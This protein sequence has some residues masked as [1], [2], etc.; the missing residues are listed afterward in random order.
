MLA[1]IAN[2]IACMLLM[3]YT[4]PVSTL[5]GHKGM[6][7]HRLSLA[8]VLVALMLSAVNPWT[9]W[10]PPVSWPTAGLNIL[11]A[12]MVPIWWREAWNFL[13]SQYG[14]GPKRRATDFGVLYGG[15]HE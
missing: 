9:G 14:P 7:S 13:L 6:W 8:V 15:G 12:S 3:L 2:A 11:A 1:D 5:M 4:L 10:Y